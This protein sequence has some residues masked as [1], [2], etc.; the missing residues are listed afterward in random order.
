[1]GYVKHTIFDHLRAETSVLS[2]LLSSVPKISFDTSYFEAELPFWCL[3]E[4]VHRLSD[5]RTPSPSVVTLHLFFSL[6]RSISN[7][8]DRW[9]NPQKVTAT[10]RL[11]CTDWSVYAVVLFCF[12]FLCGANKTQ[13]EA[14]L[15]ALMPPGPLTTNTLWLKIS[16]SQPWQPPPSLKAMA[17]KVRGWG[18]TFS[19]ASCEGENFLDVLV[20]SWRILTYFP[21]IYKY[22]L[23]EGVFCFKCDVISCLGSWGR[24][25]C[26]IVLLCMFFLQLLHWPY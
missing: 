4:E 13:I 24:S 18:A 19:N 26:C 9:R 10:P 16:D 3:D 22:S 7:P 14:Q 2:S 5:K 6:N 11:S 8:T 1:M 20:K 15:N 25:M 12:V 23:G 17:T 21:V